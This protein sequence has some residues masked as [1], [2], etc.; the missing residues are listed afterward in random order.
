MQL[1]EQANRGAPLAL[2]NELVA[3]GAD[4]NALAKG[5]RPV[6]YAAM[7]PSSGQQAPMLQWFHEHG[8]DVFA[9]DETGNTAMG[10]AAATGSVQAMTWLR[11]KGADVNELGRGG[12]PVHRAAEEDMVR[13][14]AWLRDNGAD[15]D[16]R[17][18]EG[19]H[20]MHRAAFAMSTLTIE[21]LTSV[22]KVEVDVRSVPSGLAPAHAAATCGELWCPAVLRA[23][24]DAG[25]DM[26]VR[27]PHH[28]EPLHYAMLHG[29]GALGQ[30]RGVEWLLAYGG[31][32]ANARDRYGSAP[33][34]WAAQGRTQKAVEEAR[35]ESAA[36]EEEHFGAVRALLRAGADVSARNGAGLQPMHVAA[37]Y[38]QLQ[39]MKALVAGGAD[40]NGRAEPGGERPLHFAARA[41]HVDALL[42]LQGQGADLCARNNA[43]HHAAQIRPQS[44]DTRQQEW[45]DGV[46]RSGRCL[47]VRS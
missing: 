38:Q 22:G 19:N 6:Q 42:W 31:A 1:L 33:L 25:A 45:A 28:A 9:P 5:M 35:R 14:L 41:G 17:D 8:A 16:L 26:R 4:A 24:H 7:S 3:A 15:L 20:A 2:F 39:V 27:D 47:P 37:M 30:R 46:M 12:R 10:W 21:W 18:H 11:D 13:A 43:G 32:S 29:R 44:T 36:E 34:H 40:L 23:L